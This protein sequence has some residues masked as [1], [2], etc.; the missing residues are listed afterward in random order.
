MATDDKGIMSGER[1]R[2]DLSD[3]DQTLRPGR[4]E[5]F[6]GQRELMEQLTLAIDAARGRGEALDH[7]LLYGPP[8]LGKTTLANIIANEM[9]VP[10]RSTSGPLLERKDDLAA[11]LTDLEPCEVLFIDESTGCRAWWRN[12]CI[13]RWKISSWIF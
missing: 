7:V 10:I 4:C 2:D 3:V 6:V 12:A 9:G 8:G 11:L 5:E 13:R 1:T